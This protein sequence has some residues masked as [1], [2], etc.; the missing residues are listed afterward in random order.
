MLSLGLLRGEDLES[1]RF[2]YRLGAILDSKFAENPPVVALDG[3]KG[4]EEPLA[5]LT[6]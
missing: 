3:I 2:A 6:I 5:Y 1:G 4:N